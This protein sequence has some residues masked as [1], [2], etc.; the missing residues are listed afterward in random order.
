MSNPERENGQKVNQKGFQIFTWH[1]SIESSVHG[2]LLSECTALSHC[3]TLW[4]VAVTLQCTVT[5]WQAA[6]C[7]HT[8][9]SSALQWHR[10]LSQAICGDRHPGWLINSSEGRNQA[11]WFDQVC[12]FLVSCVFFVI[13]HTMTHSD[14]EWS[15]FK[16]FLLKWR[17]CDTEV[18]TISHCVT[19]VTV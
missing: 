9:C 10:L 18:E 3:V 6:V 2:T 4:Q 11:D 19:L 1:R 14:H 17:G 15:K 7:C 13:C 5:Q 16:S 12:L 8:L